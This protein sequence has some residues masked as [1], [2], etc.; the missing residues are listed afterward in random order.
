MKKTVMLLLLVVCAS[1][2]WA[3]P[4]I[5]GEITELWINDS[6]RTNIAFVSIGQYFDT[7]CRE[8]QTNYLIMD[9]SEPSMKEAYS[10]AL[11]AF[12]SGKEVSIK[13]IGQCFGDLEK[14]KLINIFK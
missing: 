8:A 10:M 2:S 4:K 12:M 7:P 13:G 3:S 1:V 11:A 6:T 9:F 5:K 14:L